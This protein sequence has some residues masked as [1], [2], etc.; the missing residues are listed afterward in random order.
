M[1]NK[2][3]FLLILLLS[4]AVGCET[5]NDNGG[6]QNNNQSNNQGD[7]GP[8]FV[9]IEDKVASLSFLTVE[10]VPYLFD[11][12]FCLE[13]GVNHKTAGTQM[14]VLSE[15]LSSELR[16]HHYRY[17]AIQCINQNTKEFHIYADKVLW[18]VAAGEP[19]EEYLI[20]VSTDYDFPITYP[21]GEIDF[22]KDLFKNRYCDIK[23]I[24]REDY[25]IPYCLTFDFKQLPPEKYD[26]ITFTIYLR[27]G[28][29]TEFSESATI[30]FVTQ[31]AP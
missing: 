19:L 22:T 18:G 12:I 29:G 9:R 15:E 28:D 23:N 7:P 13:I 27:T 25:M 21:E 31:S 24:L 16:K 5:P 26:E 17:R 8:S 6:A 11:E 2:S 10:G 14:W 20:F 3:L 1:K 30:D 4:F